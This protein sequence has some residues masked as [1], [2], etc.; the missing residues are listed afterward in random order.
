VQLPS[1]PKVWFSKLLITEVTEM[2]RR[3]SVFP[4]W[5]SVFPW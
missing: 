1:S 3:S 5:F 4:P 2:T